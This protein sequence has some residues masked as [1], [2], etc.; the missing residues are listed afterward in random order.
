VLVP[1]IDASYKTKLYFDHQGVDALSQ[2]PFWLLNGRVTYVVPGNEITLS[3]WVKNLT[4]EAYLVQSFDL[5]LAAD[6]I[7]DS[8]GD[9]R[10][11]GVTM[12]LS[13]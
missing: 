2:A 11:F 6:T 3:A 1:R 8:F 4:D 7:I 13:F 9:P 5:R 10:T 12:N